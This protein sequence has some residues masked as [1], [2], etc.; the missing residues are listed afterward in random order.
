MPREPQ[1]RFA[2]NGDVHIAYQV[3]GDGP[4]DLLF[5]DS[6]FHHVEMVWEV[7]EFARLLRRLSSFSRL[8]HFDRR[9]TGLSDAVAVDALPDLETQVDDVLAVLDAAEATRPAVLG[10]VDGTLIAMLL[11][12]SHPDRCGAL[13]LYSASVGGH[14]WPDEAIDSVPSRSQTTWP[15]TGAVG[16][17]RCWP[18]A[19]PATTDSSNSSHGYSVRRC[20]PARS[21]ISFDSR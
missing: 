14:G 4:I 18:R 17:C 6:W 2:R 5:V 20:A 7:P 12:A 13:V 3:V 9:G 16:G 21:A 8:I 11:A 1:T 15:T 10:V 19:G